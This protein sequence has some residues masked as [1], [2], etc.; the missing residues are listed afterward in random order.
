M[1]G[2][3][4]VISLVKTPWKSWLLANSKNPS[5]QHAASVQRQQCH[6]CSSLLARL[7]SQFRWGRAYRSAVYTSRS[8]V[9]VLR[10]SSH[11]QL[12]MTC[13]RLMH[14]VHP[15][16]VRQQDHHL[17]GLGLHPITPY[18]SSV[19]ATRRPDKATDS[20][21]AMLILNTA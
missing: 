16:R 15:L 10:Q 4:A 14:R 1:K 17:I 8:L 18:R 3:L 21:I 9:C 19:P 12:L 5:S 6:C 13:H 2:V 20:E 11:A 7:Q